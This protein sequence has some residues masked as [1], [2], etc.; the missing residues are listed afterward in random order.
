MIRI[1]EN[2]IL[3]KE[4]V[5]LSPIME[6]DQQ[7]LLNISRDPRIWQYNPAFDD[8]KYFLEKWFM[9]AIKQKASGARCPFMIYYQSNPIGS[10]S[11]YNIDNENNTV[12]IGY[13]WLHPDYWGKGINT[14]I[15]HL[16]LD[17]AFHQCQVREIYFVIDFLNLRS[18]AAVIKLGAKEKEIYRD[19]LMRP[20][21]TMRDS[22][23]YVILKNQD[24]H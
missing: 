2:L 3:Q 11:F 5:S 16:L 18:R 22:I 4:D 13:T 14:T 8:P 6:N 21:G 9:P 15:K 12:N 7:A 24:N 17:Y 10:T 20:D 1:N 23:V 19:H